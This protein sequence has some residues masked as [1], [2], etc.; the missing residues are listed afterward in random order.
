MEK[1]SIYLRSYLAED[2]NYLVDRCI[3]AYATSTSDHWRVR[4][5]PFASPLAAYEQWLSFSL[6]TIDHSIPCAHAIILKHQKEHETV[7]GLIAITHYDPQFHCGLLG[8]YI[9]PTERG[10]SIQM[11]AKKALFQLL[12]TSVETL[13]AVISIHNHSSLRGM[14]KLP[15][16]HLLDERQVQK[17]PP[18]IASE[19][20]KTRD[21]VHV[22]QIDLAPY[23]QSRE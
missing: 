19:I 13:Y 23:R 21:P 7:V 10:K 16:K 8:T 17:L 18:F 12:P 14:E 3:A 15:Y 11:H 4:E 22:F 9:T 20:W 2:C 5:W 1:S 6:Q